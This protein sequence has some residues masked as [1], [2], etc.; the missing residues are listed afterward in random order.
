MG[1]ITV[2]VDDETE[3]FFRKTVKETIGE[4]K[5]TLGKAITEALDKWTREKRQ[6]K[7]KKRVLQR[8]N[9]GLYKLPKN[10]KFNRNEIYEERTRKIS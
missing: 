6:D 10:Y 4:G 8:L 9:K 1:T 2:N 3:M 5:G 7:I